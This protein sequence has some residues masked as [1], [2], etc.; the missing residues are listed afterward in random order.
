MKSLQQEFTV[1]FSYAV[2][3]TSGL[4]RADNPLLT[5]VVR[6]DGNKG[7][8]K[9]LFVVDQFVAEANP[10]LLD[11]ISAYIKQHPAVFT[12]AAPPII[13]PGGEACKNDMQLVDQL[14][15]AVHRFHIDRHSYVAAVGGG[16][17]LDLVGFAAAIAHR[18]IRHIRIPTTVLAQN[19][20]GVGVKNGVN[21]FNKK[22][23]TGTFSPPFAVLND[24]DFLRTLDERDWRAGIAEAIKVSL[25]KDATFFKGI[26]QNAQKLQDRDMAAMEKLIYRCAEMHLQ[27]IGTSG[28]PFEKG[29]SRPLDFGHWAAHTLEQLTDY[30]VRHGEAVAIGIALDS[31]YSYLA[32]ML[33]KAEWQEILALIRAI[34]FDL[35]V[36]ELA[37][38][39][40]KLGQP[41]AILK[42]LTDFQEHLG[43]ELTIMLLEQIG[44]GVE[45]HEMDVELITKA[46]QLLEA[47]QYTAAAIKN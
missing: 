2:H 40:T 33:T 12:L 41:L 31:T 18:G 32:G 8:R 38:P 4:F 29:S 19:D 14:Q 13:V 42:G 44:R 17:V 20:S 34:G 43:G 22:N 36:P 6:N 39:G 9:I 10:G 37:K 11:Q 46:V 26:Q 27:H 15:E 30:R 45:V 5:E 25:I 47:E 21:N 23:F 3:F 16:A 7:P 24:F 35:Y 1:T 28:D